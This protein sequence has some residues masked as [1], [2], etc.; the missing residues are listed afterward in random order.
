MKS[1]KHS[2]VECITTTGDR[3]EGQ[4]GCRG[5]FDVGFTRAKVLA[6][7][8]KLDFI[9]CAGLFDYLS[10][11]TPKAFVNLFF[12]SRQPGRLVPALNM[13]D[14]KSFSLAQGFGQWSSSFWIQRMGALH[15]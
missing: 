2:A 5:C 6:A 10:G 12:E 8:D 14:S 1:V 15:G 9:Y 3:M 13:S 4:P 7:S 11:V